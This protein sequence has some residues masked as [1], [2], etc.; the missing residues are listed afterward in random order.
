MLSVRLRYICLSVSL[1]GFWLPLWYLQP[2]LTLYT[3]CTS[4]S[5]YST[6]TI[7]LHVYICTI[8]PFP[9]NETPFLVELLCYTN[10]GENNLTHGRERSH[11]WNN[12]MEAYFCSFQ[13]PSICMA[14]GSAQININHYKTHLATLKQICVS[15]FDKKDMSRQ[16]FV[17]QF[18]KNQKSYHK[19]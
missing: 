19:E 16:T 7:T 1:Y 17:K 3:S 8:T 4:N 2:L 15:S 14:V 9:I 11:N 6:F 13:G 18:K 12:W 5:H 10:V